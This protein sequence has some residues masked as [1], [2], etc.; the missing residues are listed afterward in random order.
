MNMYFTMT[1][2][3]AEMAGG[4][5]VDVIVD[6]AHDPANDY[7][8]KGNIDLSKLQRVVEE[9]GAGSVATSAWPS[10]ST[11]PGARSTA[12][13]TCA[14]WQPGQSGMK[15]PMLRRNRRAGE[16]LFHPAARSGL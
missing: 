15:F 8:L 2:Q 4:V 13:R 10:V 14:R 16:C 11:W 5:F 9:H 1:R 7:P 6:E 3:H 12:W